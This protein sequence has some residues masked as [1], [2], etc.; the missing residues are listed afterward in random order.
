MIK[1]E[2]KTACRLKE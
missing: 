1:E 2:Y